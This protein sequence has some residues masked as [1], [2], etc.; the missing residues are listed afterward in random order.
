[1]AK[2]Y[3]LAALVVTAA[4]FGALSLVDDASARSLASDFSTDNLRVIYNDQE[5][6]KNEDNP[7]RVACTYNF[8]LKFN[9]TIDSDTPFAAGDSA[10]ANISGFSSADRMP[11][12]FNKTSPVPIYDGGGTQVAEWYLGDSNGIS[13][14]IVEG[15]AGK[16]HIEGEI[17]TPNQIHSSTC[18]SRDLTQDIAVGKYGTIPIKSADS[19]PIILSSGS[20]APMANTASS[21]SSSNS[22]MRITNVSPT[23]TVNA[24]YKNGGQSNVLPEEVIEDFYTETTVTIPTS[25]YFV[26]VYARAALPAKVDGVVSF[27]N[28][29]GPNGHDYGLVECTDTITTACK[30]RMDAP[31]GVSKE[32]YIASLKEA[33]NEGYIP[34]GLFRNGDASTIIIYHGSQPSTF[35]YADV[36][37]NNDAYSNYGSIAEHFAASLP[38]HDKTTIAEPMSEILGENNVYGGKVMYFKSIITLN[39]TEPVSVPGQQVT[40]NT[41]MYYNLGDANHTKKTSSFER[42]VAIS[43]G[44]SGEAVS[45]GTAVLTVVDSANKTPI[46]GAEFELYKGNVSTGITKTSGS[47]GKLQVNGLDDGEYRWVQTGFAAPY[48]LDTTKYYGSADLN[49]EVSSFRIEGDEGAAL[50]ATNTRKPVV[51]TYDGGAHGSNTFAELVPSRTY[52]YGD[53]IVVPDNDVVNSAAEIGWQ[54][55]G[56]DRAIATTATED[57]TYTATWK[58]EMVNVEARLIWLD[59]NNEDGVRPENSSVIANLGIIDENGTFHAKDESIAFDNDGLVTFGNQVK[60]INGEIANYSVYSPNINGYNVEVRKEGNVIIVEAS[61][62][63]SVRLKVNKV[64]DDNQNYEGLR[65]E[66]V[67]FGINEDGRRTGITFDLDTNEEFALSGELPKYRSLQGA[68]TLIDYDIFEEDGSFYNS[69]II[70]DSA[71]EFTVT[72]ELVAAEPVSYE[73]D[74]IEVKVDDGEEMPEDLE[75]GV[76]VRPITNGAP[77][78][79]GSSDGKKTIPVGSDMLAEL[80]DVTFEKAGDYDYEISV[81]TNKGDYGDDENG[82]YTMRVSVVRNKDTNELEIVSVNY[83]DKDGNLVDPSEIGFKVRKMNIDNP[84]TGVESACIYFVASG[85]ILAAAGVGLFSIRKRR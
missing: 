22:L 14:R 76:T 47:N 79:D 31:D 23:Q 70:K 32:E 2:K 21:L 63:P 54:F 61:H 51:I 25:S 11:F 18:T 50:Y 65:P 48:Y 3:F 1:M 17:T 24:I 81:D 85:A 56:W 55:D 38:Y 71:Y 75:I 34:Y 10:Y 6:E 36:M 19:F 33:R 82:K 83:Y 69:T 68:G 35:S 52:A 30:K 5:L 12:S 60:Y 46:A 37:A 44:S 39:F 80:G 43:I 13:I 8:A 7:A 84:D 9:Y 16:N 66:T 29:V 72:N 73:F 59:A 42:S 58:Q 53:A 78:P 27:Q 64:W 4:S 62:N 28:G 26:A 20:L 67:T 77:M 45:K 40:Q 15:G 74:P 49:A 57:T 41:T